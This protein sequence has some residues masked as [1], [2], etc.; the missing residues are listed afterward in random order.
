MKNWATQKTEL[1]IVLF[2]MIAMVCN[3]LAEIPR[4][5]YT[6]NG[7]AETISKMTLDDLTIDQNIVST[8]QIPNQI[9]VHNGMIYL[10]NSGT[11]DIMVIDAANDS[12][13]AKTIALAEGNNPW[14]IG[15]AGSNKAYVTNFNTNN[16]SVIDLEAGM[17]LKEIEVG[18]APEGILVLNNNAY[19]TNTGYAGWGVPYDQA[20]VSVIDILSDSVINTIPVPINAQNLAVDPMGRIHVV[21]TGNYADITGQVAI[22]DLFA[23][24]GWTPAVVDTVILGGSPA[25]I[26]ITSAGKAYCA[27]WGDGTNGFLYAYNAFTDSVTHDVD[28]PILVGP[29]ISNLLYDGKEDMIWIPY[30]AVWDGDGFVQKFDA[31]VD[32]VIWKSGVVGNGTQDIAILEA[33]SDSDPWADAVVSFTPGTGAGFGANYYPENILGAPD[34]DPNLSETNASAKPQELLS[35]GHGGEIVL[36]FTDNKIVNGDGIDFT[37][38]E[39][40]FLSFFDGSVYIEAAIISVSQDGDTWYQFPYDTTDMSGLAGVT[41]MADNQH[42]TDPEVSGGDQFDLEDLGLAWASY[43]KITD[44]GDIYQEGLWNGD[45]DLDA[46]IAVNSEVTTSV[47]PQYASVRT[48]NF[49]LSQNYPNP[50]NPETMIRYTLENQQPVKLTVFN[51]RGQVVKTLVNSVQ[52]QGEYS[53]TWN[54]TDEYNRSVA[55]G[56]YFYQL[57]CGEQNLVRKMTLLK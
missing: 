10:V 8:G 56:V 36:Q 11:D 54:G 16:V 5:I 19:V 55:N 18:T 23:G 38:F 42:P 1:F 31:D 27:A 32:S 26:V 17:V 24:P 50:F 46:V 48:Q 44:L 15:F 57:Q 29:N 39:N 52:Q 47:D 21:C 25:D 53:T 14:A 30:M 6:M 4:T 49:Q 2:L 13:I 41:P 35:L 51:S 40:A 43:V 3:V 9:A 20:S 7:S 45:F 22:I 28:D 33:I 34:P 12:E 37:V